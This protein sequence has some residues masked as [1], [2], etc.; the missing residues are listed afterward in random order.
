[1]ELWG[2]PT[3]PADRKSDCAELVKTGRAG[4]W[5]RS[6]TSNQRK[7]MAWRDYRVGRLPYDPGPPLAASAL[8]RRD[9]LLVAK[10]FWDRHVSCD[11]SAQES[12]QAFP[13]L[14]GVGITR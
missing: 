10:L 12:E 8:L 3:D 4:H 14:S 5:R 9:Y 2:R 7:T 13:K 1:M 6:F 11:W